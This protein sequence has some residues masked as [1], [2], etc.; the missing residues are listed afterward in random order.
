MWK[1]KQSLFRLKIIAK[2]VCYLTQL[3]LW[4]LL[5]DAWLH[6]RIANHTWKVFLQC[7]RN[8]GRPW[9]CVVMMRCVIIQSRLTNCCRCMGDEGKWARREVRRKQ[10]KSYCC[11][12]NSNV[13]PDLCNNGRIY[14]C[15]NARSIREC[16]TPTLCYIQLISQSGCEHPWPLLCWE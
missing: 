10:R 9:L 12:S 3:L 6:L 11:V 7:R 5:W 4:D 8:A 13:E 16:H 15:P 2:H 1:T 14:Y